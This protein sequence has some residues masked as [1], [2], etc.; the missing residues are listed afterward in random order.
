M[1]S[2]TYD[3]F[4][5]RFLNGTMSGLFYKTKASSTWSYH[6]NTIITFT[7][8]GTVIVNYGSAPF[9]TTD[10]TKLIYYFLVSQ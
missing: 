9:N 5:L 1:E 4:A 7:N 2:A 3:I 10:I 6:N 8:Y